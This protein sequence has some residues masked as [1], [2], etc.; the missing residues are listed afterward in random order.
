MP[1]RFAIEEVFHLRQRGVIM[2]VGRML[3]GSVDGR[4][5][6]R[7]EQTGRRVEILGVEL[8]PPPTV[9]PDRVTLIVD[10]ASPAQPTRG[11]VLVTPA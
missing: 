11:M 9:D 6:L 8:L 7:D 5:T 3:E 4:T 10:P 1:V 2:A